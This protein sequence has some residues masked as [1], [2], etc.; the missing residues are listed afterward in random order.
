MLCS[1][2]AHPPRYPQLQPE[3]IHELQKVFAVLDQRGK[4]VIVVEDIA[5]LQRDLLTSLNEPVP[6]AEQATRG[7]ESVMQ[8]I[9][10]GAKQT[11]TFAD[12]LL[13]MRDWLLPS[14][15]LC[16]EDP[17]QR[18]A[19]HRRVALF[20]L[21][22]F[23]SDSRWSSPWLQDGEPWMCGQEAPDLVELSAVPDVA[24]RS[25][26]RFKRTTFIENN[27]AN[28]AA[29]FEVIAR[30]HCARTR[31]L[32]YKVANSIKQA[33][34]LRQLLEHVEGLLD[35]LRGLTLF[36][37]PVERAELQRTFVILFYELAR[38]PA[39]DEPSVLDMVAYFANPAGQLFISNA[40]SLQLMTI[41]CLVAGG[42]RVGGLP[43]HDSSHEAFALAATDASIKLILLD[44]DSFS[45]LN[46]VRAVKFY[47]ECENV[48]LRLIAL[49]LLGA[50]ARDR[51]D[52]RQFL[53]LS[54]PNQG[55]PDLN[56]LEP[57]KHLLSALGP[58]AFDPV[59]MLA[60]LWAVHQL[61]LEPLVPPLELAQL[62][63][64]GAV[65]V[66]IMF[67]RRELLAP[68][69]VSEALQLLACAS[70]GLTNLAACD[71]MASSLGSSG[72][73]CFSL[74]ASLFADHSQEVRVAALE[75]C[76]KLCHIGSFCNAV[77]AAA[78]VLHGCLDHADPLT[79]AG[80]ASVVVAAIAV[81]GFVQPFL[82]AAPRSRSVLQRMLDL[83]SEYAMRS[84]FVQAIKFAATAPSAHVRLLLC[85]PF[86]LSTHD[87]GTWECNIIQV[88]LLLAKTFFESPDAD[89]SLNDVYS[90]AQ[91]TFDFPLV[92]DALK[93]LKNILNAGDQEADGLGSGENAF[94]MQFDEQAIADLTS[95][96]EIV[97][98]AREKA[99]TFV[100]PSALASSLSAAAASDS[101]W[102]C[103]DAWRFQEPGK[104]SAEVRIWG[105]LD[106]VHAVLTRLADAT[107]A[108][109]IQAIDR[110]KAS[111]AQ[112]VRLAS[113]TGELFVRYRVSDGR[114][115]TLRIAVKTRFT[116]LERLLRSHL[117][118]TY[119]RITYAASSSGGAAGGAGAGPAEGEQVRVHSQASW[120]QCIGHFTGAVVD[121]LLSAEESRL[122][123]EHVTHE[124]GMLMDTAS[125]DVRAL[126]APGQATFFRTRMNLGDISTPFDALASE[127]GLEPGKVR[128]LDAMW[129]RLCTEGTLDCKGY[130]QFMRN[131]SA[132]ASANEKALERNF[133]AMDVD[134]SG[135]L[136]FAEWV[137]GVAALECGEESKRMQMF[138]RSYDTDLDEKLSLLELAD[139]LEDANV[140]LPRDELT[141]LIQQRFLPDGRDGCTFDEFV[142][143]MTRHGMSVEF[144]VN[145]VL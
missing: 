139:M 103:I 48:E 77:C 91:H 90:F 138:F 63:S 109:R 97:Q 135:K 116:D 108:D 38:K 111:D 47:L 62:A 101:A 21:V 13:A 93:A 44:A 46:V 106:H 28:N 51:M 89:E 34:V 87:G 52:V 120:E 126:R 83:S 41:L 1:Q 95:M 136:D 127:T 23:P 37:T 96:L 57:V 6:D 2:A 85:T 16:N 56:V 39:D 112:A 132:D 20:F 68:E 74:V 78:S 14:H 141:L 71:D 125:Y 5:R 134:R 9:Q 53:L 137:R 129:R 72:G 67:A 15:A 75:A 76:A 31:S 61:I 70:R 118:A 30:E 55:D 7:A 121:L 119:V 133:F 114:Q 64:A 43:Y 144:F 122:V 45:G 81:Y 98:Q 3:Q 130:V 65:R 110:C 80:S 143:A 42:P 27:Q 123:T 82:E 84:R 105:I 117:D 59:T 32:F 102:R 33:D 22:P 36:R 128:Q 25:F 69:V 24:R 124:S 35:A 58:G 29:D 100:S 86:R 11:A 49:Q 17:Y 54:L 8:A 40:F 79:R 50:L 99:G 88:L 115:G 18:L 12:F 140:G 26:T 131:I 107:Y 104:P 66:I 142:A 94:V 145:K 4:Q 19:F 92:S 60:L 113:S 73:T 10:S